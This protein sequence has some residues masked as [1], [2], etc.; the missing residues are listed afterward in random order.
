MKKNLLV[1]LLAALFCHFSFAQVGIN[2]DN[3]NPDPSAMLDVKSTT[4]G[5]LP[6]RVALAAIN[7]AAPVVAP[8]TGLL[9]YNTA[10]A[11][12]LPNNVVPGYYFWNGTRWFSV[13]LPQGSNP[14]DLVAWNGTQWIVVPAGTNGQVLS[15]VNGVPGWKASSSLCGWPVIKSHMVG[16]VAP[17]TKNVTYGTVNNITGEAAKCWI[18][19]NLGSDH[20]AYTV[21]D[22]AESSAGWYWQF[23]RKQG[24]KHDGTTLTPA[25]SITS[26]SESSDWLAAN[27]PCTIELAA[28]WRVPTYSEW[29]NVDDAGG[30]SNS[31]GPWGALKMHYAGDLVNTTGALNY[32]GSIG[33]YWSSSQSTAANAYYF[34]FTP[35]TSSIGNVSK[36]FGFPVRCIRE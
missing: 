8:A 4:R 20:Q 3:S 17:V 28:P 31:A 19:S 2:S 36:A 13:Q 25:W 1:I 14:G 24:Y 18:T 32:R 12:T 29:Y 6:P 15:M 34:V 30:W 21:S 27:D 26:I 22:N 9:V 11:G 23:N 5:L 33:Y 16:V 10:T 35:S 7:T